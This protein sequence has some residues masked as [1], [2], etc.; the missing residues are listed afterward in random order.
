M[1][2]LGTI[3]RAF[4]DHPARTALA[5]ADA[6]VTYR[7]LEELVG[8]IAARVGGAGAGRRIGVLTG[9]DLGTYASILAVL[10][11]GAAYVPL[12]RKNPAARNRAIVEQ[13]D[14][15]LV[16]SSKPTEE[17][18]RLQSV[19]PRRLDAVFAADVTERRRVSWAAP[20]GDDLAYLFFTS[21]TTGVPKGVPIRHRN[22]DAFAAAVIADPSYAFSPNDRFLQMFELTFDLSVMSFLAPLAVG[23]SCHVVPDVGIASL[24][25]AR[26]LDER[27]ITV[28]LMVPSVLSYLRRYLEELR[29]PALRH[30][31]FCGEALSHSSTVA[32]SRSVP[33]ARIR[34]VYGPTEATIFC[35][36]FE[37]EEGVS[38]EQ[39]VNDVVPIGKP[40]VGTSLRIVDA[41]SAAVPDGAQGELC[42]LGEQLASGYWRD[43]E[44]SRAAFVAAAD[45]QVAYRTGDLALRNS[46]G[47]YVYCGRADAQIQVDGHRVELGEVEH[48]LRSFLEGVAVAAAPVRTEDGRQEFVAFVEQKAVDERRVKEYLLT[49]LPDYMLPRRVIGVAEFP[50]NLNGKVDRK[51][52]L[53][54]HL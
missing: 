47:N 23:A 2:L 44:R 43:A 26:L 15:D 39:S 42:L 1:E 36:E 11:S 6:A 3:A 46:F 9:D 48:H 14:L 21:G 19:L 18:E 22:L 37:W 8:G 35:T 17:L 25:I 5:A 52:L 13:A 4:R 32:W 38:A 30:S 33:A 40:L 53:R 34:N 28:A 20:A 49:K 54:R 51:E 41:H 24:E 16:L 31:L 50:L 10:A 12:N 45:G 29:F 7:E 27:E